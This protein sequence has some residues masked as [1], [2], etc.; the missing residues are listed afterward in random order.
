[1]GMLQVAGRSE[2][3]S[4]TLKQQ[5]LRKEPVNAIQ[6]KSMISFDARHG[7]TSVSHAYPM[8]AYLCVVSMERVLNDYTPYTIQ[9]R[10][11]LMCIHN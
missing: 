2:H 4:N 9:F 6:M 10:I 7:L 5:H 1:M 11:D 8:C 3:L